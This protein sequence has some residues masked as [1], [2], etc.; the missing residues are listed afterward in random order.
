MEDRDDKMN[1]ESSEN[2]DAQSEYETRTISKD[3]KRLIIRSDA[4]FKEFNSDTESKINYE[5]NKCMTIWIN[6]PPADNRC[7]C[8]GSRHISELK[9]FG[10][11]GDPLVGDFSGAFLVK[12]A[13][14]LVVDNQVDTCW[15]C[16]EC[17]IL[18]DDESN[19]IRYKDYKKK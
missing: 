5:K 15:E 18:D 4:V 1:N 19:K 3:G 6:P 9:P 8:C 7:E 11:P 17:F 12:H 14:C 16:R 10:G 13:R 2:T